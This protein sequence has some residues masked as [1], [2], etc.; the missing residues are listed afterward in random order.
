MGRKQLKFK[1][2][3]VRRAIEAARA[4]GMEIAGVRITP[5]GAIEVMVNKPVGLP[6][7]PGIGE[8][9]NPWDIK[10]GNTTKA[11]E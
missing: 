9:Q 1:Q 5:D 8:G 10:Y 6:A 2:T 4:A 11:R 7:Q 3:D